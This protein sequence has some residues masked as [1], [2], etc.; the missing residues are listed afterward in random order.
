[1]HRVPLRLVRAL[2][3]AV[4]AID[5]VALAAI[6]VH[7]TATTTRTV[8]R[9]PVGALAAATPTPS[10]PPT[11]AAPAPGGPVSDVPPALPVASAVPAAASTA[12]LRASTSP[13]PP[14][15]SSPSPTP[16]ANCPL[17]LKP[18]EQSGGLQSLIDFAP[19]FGPF[20]AEAFAAAS[21][22][23]PLLQL[24]GPIL[25]QYP[26]IGARIQPELNAFLA[27]WEHLLEAVFSVIQPAYEPHRQQVL[28]A[29]TA[30]ASSLAPYAEKLAT[31]PLG[32]CLVDLEAA[33]VNDTRTTE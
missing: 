3:V 12:A 31:S 29:E 7:T 30:L 19:A 11:A 18:P 13:A 6:A 5:L 4:I 17:P 1:M 21:A 9:L 32:G 15:T 25:A 2:V 24:L 20:S 23:Q 27:P 8:T 10:A 14:P 16:T 33:L 22:Y 26:V 28:S